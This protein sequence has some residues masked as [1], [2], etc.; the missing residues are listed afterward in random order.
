MLIRLLRD[1]WWLQ[2][3][4]GGGG[5]RRLN[6]LRNALLINKRRNQKKKI[7][8][9]TVRWGHYII[10]TCTTFSRCLFLFLSLFLSLVVVV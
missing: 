4:P 6:I 10:T 8:F 2:V 9:L 7:F 1:V 3:F 5:S